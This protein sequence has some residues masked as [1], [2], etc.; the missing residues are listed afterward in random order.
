MNEKNP[1]PAQYF[2]TD[3]LLAL[4]S[5]P[6]NTKIGGRLFQSIGKKIDIP[7]KEKVSD[8]LNSS[9]E[10]IGIFLYMLKTV[11]VYYKVIKNSFSTFSKT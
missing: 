1:F 4:K 7:E 2:K 3:K 11:E 10:E 5:D 8:F 6:S 9:I